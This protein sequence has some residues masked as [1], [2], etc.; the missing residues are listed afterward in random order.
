M[1]AKIFQ[2]DAFAGNPFSGNPA[3][4]CLLD[5]KADDTWMQNLASEMNLSETAFVVPEGDGYCLRWFTPTVEVELCGHATLASAHI[6]WETST[7]APS[8]PA[9]F[10]TQSGTL[11]ALKDGNLIRLDFPSKPPSQCQP[12][13]ELEKALGVHATFTGNNQMDYFL[14]IENDE[15]LREIRPDFNLLGSLGMRGVIVTALSSLPEYDFV[16]R[17]FAPGAGIDE[18]PVT[19]S[20]HCCLAPYWAEKLGRNELTGFQAS[21]R[22]GE[23]AVECKSNRVIL[24]GRAVT[25]FSGQLNIDC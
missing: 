2:V 14:E 18:D 15:R 1:S 13:P 19:G 24:G 11:T 6:L 20:A 25:I 17:F 21:S 16:S 5:S 12:I 4:V 22:G 23:V 8:Q 9:I 7:L 3:A 10:E